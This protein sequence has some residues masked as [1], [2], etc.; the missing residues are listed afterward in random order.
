MPSSLELAEAAE[1]FV[2]PA[3]LIE[4]GFAPEVTVLKALDWA[5]AVV[6]G[7]AEGLTAEG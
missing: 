7:G 5:G 2:V 3:L 6:A 1:P 4:T